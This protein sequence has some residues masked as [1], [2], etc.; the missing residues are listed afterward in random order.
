MFLPD[1]LEGI[2]LVGLVFG[3]LIVT[4]VGLVLGL[5][6][7]GTLLNLLLWQPLL[8]LIRINRERLDR[9][10]KMLVAGNSYQWLRKGLIWSWEHGL[11]QYLVVILCFYF[12]SQIAYWHNYLASSWG[13]L[14]ALFI[15]VGGIS[16]AYYHFSLDE[17]GPLESLKLTLWTTIVILSISYFLV[18]LVFHYRD[19]VLI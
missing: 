18:A 16:F 1:F 8:W 5:V 9:F 13:I 11:F 7:I 19:L 3:S 10:A 14:T 6:L 17:K 2:K 15:P 12:G 4:I